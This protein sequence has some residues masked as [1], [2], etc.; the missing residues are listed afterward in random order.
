M[1]KINSRG[2]LRGRLQAMP[3]RYLSSRTEGGALRD[4]SHE[5]AIGLFTTL[6]WAAAFGGIVGVPFWVNKVATSVIFGTL[7]AGAIAGRHWS[8][9][10]RH[11][12]AMHAFAAINALMIFPL[13]ALSVHMT[14]PTLM[15]MAL[16]PAYAAVCG[17]RWA[18]GLGGA[19]ILASIAVVVA[20]P[21]GIEI[22]KPFP[23]PPEAQVA[24][25]VIGLVSV[26][27]P[28][29]LVFGRLRASLQA[30]ELEN[31]QRRETEERVRAS[32][33][34]FRVLF[35]ESPQPT[36]LVEDGRFVAANRAT[37]ALLGLSDPVQLVGRTPREI[38]PPLQPDGEEELSG[39]KRTV[40]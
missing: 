3:E 4:P 7:V 13:M 14:A 25:A 22:P 9:R 2:S 33:E 38:S 11:V 23:T 6:A 5:I 21:A 24:A 36:L 10:G 16:L 8:L 31:R 40:V 35:E 1:R 37:L 17:Q 19:Y 30:L 26:I 20:P 12:M 18:F 34:R 15:M 39:L 28:L 27:A 29:A 32:E